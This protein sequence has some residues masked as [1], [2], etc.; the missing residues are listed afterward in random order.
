M[1]RHTQ[2]IG[3]VTLGVSMI[4]IRQ[5]NSLWLFAITGIIFLVVSVIIH[6]SQQQ[7]ELK[8]K[9]NH[10]QQWY[11]GSRFRA[12]RQHLFMKGKIDGQH[13]HQVRY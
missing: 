10:C 11:S 13:Y 7:R 5:T 8:I 3:L 6:R 2:I 4:A 12:H 9:C 1:K